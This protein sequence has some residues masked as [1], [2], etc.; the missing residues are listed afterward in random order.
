MDFSLFPGAIDP[1]HGFEVLP[2]V[3]LVGFKISALSPIVPSV[4]KHQA[5]LKGLALHRANHLLE[6]F[7][8]PLR[9]GIADDHTL[10]PQVR[11]GVHAGE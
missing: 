10:F 3:F 11:G 6:T 4:D 1:E 9:G 5:L 7:G 8:K 2:P